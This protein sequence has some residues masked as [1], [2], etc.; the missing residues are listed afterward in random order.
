MPKYA[1][2]GTDREGKLARGVERFD[3][4]EAAEFALFERDLRGVTLDEK[5]SVLQMEITS[6]VKRKEVMHLSRQL[7]AFLRAGIP[8][9][10]GI[11][12]LGTEASKPPMKRL[13]ADIEEGLRAGERFSDCLDRHPK[14]FPPFYRGIM[15]SAELTGDLDT[16]LDQLG[17]YL[18]RDLDARRKITSAMIYPAIIAAM[19]LVTVVV[20]AAFVLPRF[21]KFFE[22]LEAELPL[23]TRMLL[24]VT[25]FVTAWWWAL[26]VGALAAAVLFFG[27]IRTPA[28]RRLWDRTVLRMPVIGST[29]QYALVERYC[30]ILASMVGAGVT[31][32]VA[33]QVASGSI[34]NVVYTRAL[35]H[36]EEAMLEGEGLAGPLA[37][38]G[39]FPPT[40]VQ[41]MRVGE[42][43]GSLDV[44]L[45][46]AAR[47]YERE[48]DY[49]LKRVMTLIEPIV[50]LGMG[51]TVGFVAMALV[52]A[53]YG[54]FNQVQV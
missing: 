34:R 53:M 54:I 39:L 10:Q 14:T 45:E 47:Y 12:T 51:L 52:S 3:S 36:V 22:S 20:L 41:M 30:R 28:G 37:A 42:D 25:D 26:G 13:M 9:L 2:A 18:E 46:V 4:R 23:P 31:L 1:Y 43:T 29:V 35:T 44:Q 32:P 16:V 15:R 48:L 8:I 27:G 7:A 17:D 19:S 5:R 38:T 33:L 40:A 21:K 49:K 24:A 50:I 11:H 6:A